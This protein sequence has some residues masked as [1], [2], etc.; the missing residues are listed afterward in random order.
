MISG[1][2]RTDEC[3]LHDYT[4]VA[5]V[6]DGSDERNQDNLDIDN[7]SREDEYNSGSYDWHYKCIGVIYDA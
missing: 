4:N 2:K 3:K 7:E 5:D 1:L 6:H